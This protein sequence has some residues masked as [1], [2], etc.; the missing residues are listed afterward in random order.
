MDVFVG[1]FSRTT[2]DGDPLSSG[3][4]NKELP[5]VDMYISTDDMG[6]ITCTLCQRDFTQK[7]HCKRHIL[8]VHNATD[9]MTILCQVCRNPFKNRDSLRTH[10][11]KTHGIYRPK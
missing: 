2:T 7:G 9:Q 1:G 6:R 8:A 3:P 4:G 11:R 10:E 5:Y